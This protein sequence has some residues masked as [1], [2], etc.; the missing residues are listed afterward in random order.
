M[1]KVL[2]LIL[3]AM[4]PFIFISVA[5][6]QELPPVI[7]TED[8]LKLLIESIGGM[9]GAKTI[10]LVGIVLKLLLAFLSSEICGQVFKKLSGGVKL[11]I[12][13]ALSFVSGIISLKLTGLDW[14]AAILHSTTLSAFMVLSNQVYKQYFEK[15]KAVV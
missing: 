15:E 1:K 3:M 13:L 14:T 4:M 6:S 12:V 7:P 10:A 5:F 11:T 9:K 2:G 8:F